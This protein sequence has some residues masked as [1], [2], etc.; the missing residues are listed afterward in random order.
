[1][2]PYPTVKDFLSDCYQLVSAN[3]P[4]V[5]LYG[6]D[7]TKGLTILNRLIQSYSGT[8]LLTSV[9]KQV[10]FIVP[11]GT[12]YIIFCDAAY[13]PVPSAPAPT[14]VPP[15]IVT[16]A[17]RLSNLQNAW[18]SLD[19]VTYPIIDESRN[20]F[21]GSYKYDP[22]EGLPRFCIITN[23]DDYTTMRLYPSPSQEYSLSVFGKFQLPLLTMNGNMSLVP[24]YSYLFLQYATAKQIAY[25]KGRSSAWTP[26]LEKILIELT[27]DI[28]SIS[29]IN[30]NIESDHDSLL[31]GSWR[32]RAGI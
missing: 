2:L 7:T 9:A 4:T 5:P 13:I 22:Q 25:N 10:N 3:S 30:L 12:Q 1:M 20:T 26:D 24:Q 14:P 23:N 15:V 16:S 27:D 21:F 8:G 31:N 18:L 11:I 6:N 17:G 32:V 29:P 19:G 28:E